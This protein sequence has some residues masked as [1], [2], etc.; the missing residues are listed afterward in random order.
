MSYAVPVGYGFDEDTGATVVVYNNGTSKTLLPVPSE[1]GF[2]PVGTK[3]ISI[4]ENGTFIENVKD[5][6]NAE[7]TVDV[8]SGGGAVQSGTFTLS[9]DVSIT[10][11]GTTLDIGLTSQVD[12]LVV[13]MDNDSFNSM[14]APASNHWYK[15]IIAK[16]TSAIFATLPALKRSATEAFNHLF[17][18]TDWI[19]MAATSTSTCSDAM[20]TNGHA[21]AGGAYIT[22]NMGLVN[23]ANDGKITIGSNST[24]TQGMYAGTYHFVGVTGAIIPMPI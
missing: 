8:A 1:G 2:E 23:I 4:T 20:C 9:E 7:I 17:E 18:N 6:V 14:E 13:W 19:A 10:N 11:S 5:Y 16:K 22:R 15:F 21:V 24:A 12:F 3:E